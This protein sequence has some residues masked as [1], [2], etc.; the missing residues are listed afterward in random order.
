MIKL[1]ED[2]GLEVVRMLMG[3]SEELYCAIETQD[4]NDEMI[5]HMEAEAAS[6]E[7]LAEKISRQF[8]DAE[9]R[10]AKLSKTC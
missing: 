10:L 3:Y 4:L 8:P 5:M 6:A 2:Q 7:I 1:T 9:D